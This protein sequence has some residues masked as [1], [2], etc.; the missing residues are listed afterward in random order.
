M[1]KPKILLVDDDDAV[2]EYF[3]A[4]LGQRYE[5]VATNAAEQVLALARQHAPQVIVCDIDMPKM[6]GGELSSA[7]FADEELRDIPVLFLTAL[8]TP[9]QLERLSGQLGGRPAVSKSEPVARL[10]ARIEALIAH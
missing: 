5:L 1:K 8:A 9:A 3:E 7:L 4:K 2:L 10:V 6:D